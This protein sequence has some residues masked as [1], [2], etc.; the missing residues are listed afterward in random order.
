[1]TMT[2]IITK[3]YDSYSGSENGGTPVQ[4]VQGKVK[5]RAIHATRTP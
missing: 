5:E 1:M 3:G 4:L 2:V